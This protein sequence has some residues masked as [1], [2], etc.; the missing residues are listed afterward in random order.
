MSVRVI[1]SGCLLV[2]LMLFSAGTVFSDPGHWHAVGLRAGIGDSRNSES[3]QQYEAYAVFALPWRWETA[4]DWSLGPFVGAS[5]GVV[6]CEGEAFVGSIGPGV[7]LMPPG[8]RLV[9]SAGI[10]P[11]YLSRS[12]FG[13]EDFGGT[14]QFTSAVGI[15]YHFL[16]RATIGYRFQH[17]SNAGISNENPGLN[18]HLLEV[19]YRF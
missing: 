10:Y 5:A 16:Q 14:F 3:F 4:A 12:T 18:T 8:R 15:N 6:T 2:M 1:V 13:S 17:M 11:T 19:G 9:L 7:Y